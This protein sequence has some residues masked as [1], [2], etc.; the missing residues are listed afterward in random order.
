M[1]DTTPTPPV[2][3]DIDN[4]PRWLTRLEAAA[5]AGV[6]VRTL[7]RWISYGYIRASKPAGGR[8]LVDRGVLRELIEGAAA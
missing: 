6:S 7:R 5:I 3:L 8:V 1:K 4:A 2:A